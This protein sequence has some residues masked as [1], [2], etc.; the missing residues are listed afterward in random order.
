MVTK[1]PAPSSPLVAKRVRE[2]EAEEGKDCSAVGEEE[3][4]P[5]VG[6]VN[7]ARA[8]IYSAPKQTGWVKGHWPLAWS[9][10]LKRTIFASNQINQ[11]TAQLCV[12]VYIETSLP[13]AQAAEEKKIGYS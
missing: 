8:F 5:G 6:D 9:C 3:K 11:Q 10:R 13:Y 4:V 7:S 2:G 1:G 12:G